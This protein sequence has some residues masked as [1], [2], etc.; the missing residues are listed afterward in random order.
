M[1]Y[2][3]TVI[4]SFA[5]N[6]VISLFIEKVQ[7]EAKEARRKEREEKRKRWEEWKEKQMQNGSE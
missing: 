4:S 5:R 6:K 3:V 1:R 7:K 2:H